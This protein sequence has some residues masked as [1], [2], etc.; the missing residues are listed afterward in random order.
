LHRR[1]LIVALL[2]LP[3]PGAARAGD[4]LIVG[5]SED[6]MKWSSTRPTITHRYVRHLG[7]GAIRVT[8]RWAPGQSYPRGTTMIALRRAERA[9][10]GRKLVL[11]V[12]SRANRTPLDPAMRGQYC[13]F[14][15][16]LLTAAPHVKDVV[17]WNEPNSPTFWRPQFDGD[18][19]SAAPAAYERLL[20]DC[21]DALHAVRP[22]V[23]VIAASSPRGN[24][25]PAAPRPSHS[26]IRW[27]AE[28]AQAYRDSGRDRPIFDTVGHNPYPNNS[29]EPPWARH[30]GGT[31]GE[32]DYAK[33]VF[34]LTDG[35]AGTSQPVPGGGLSIWYMEDGFQTRVQP[36]R[37]HVYVGRENDQWALDAGGLAQRTAAG[38]VVD[39]A[40]Q[41]ADAMRLAYCQP[42]VGAFFNFLLA[43]EQ[44]LSGWQ[45]GLLWSDWQPKPSYAV[46]ARTVA[47]VNRGWVDC[48]AYGG[49]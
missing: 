48:A 45:S 29:A 32:G 44:S 49:G 38:R 40:T 28:L 5:V 15:S 24:D 14:V 3:A 30:P 36:D 39:Q 13:T 22:D 31:V 10:A 16:R 25:D 34:T 2:A 9:A 43:D 21:W 7:I 37:S 41:L 23:N 47:D 11:A 19:E 42:Y 1:L 46:F 17:I 20:A 6:M 18:G 26:P 35:F 33:L 4:G 12:Y 27:Y 8:F